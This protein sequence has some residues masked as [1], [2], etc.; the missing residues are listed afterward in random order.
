MHP[1]WECKQTQGCRE[2]GYEIQS[3][4][5]LASLRPRVSPHF[6][7]LWEQLCPTRHTARSACSISVEAVANGEQQSRQAGCAHCP[8]R[9]SFSSTSGGTWK[10]KRLPLSLEWPRSFMGARA[11]DTCPMAHANGTA[12]QSAG[13][14]VKQH[15]QE[16]REDYRAMPAQGQRRKI[17]S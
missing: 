13:K 12:R 15:G 8:S 17:S 1:L 7:F 6:E 11:D 9:W 10:V 5:K 3:G 2:S 4:R 14:M 16:K